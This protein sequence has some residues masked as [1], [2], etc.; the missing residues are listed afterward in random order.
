MLPG[1]FTGEDH[2]YQTLKAN[3]DSMKLI[4]VG[5][6]LTNAQGEL[7][8]IDGAY[9]AWQFNIRDFDIATD[10]YAESSIQLLKSSGID[11]ERNRREGIDS[12]RFG[13]LLIKY[14]L[15]RNRKINYICYQ[16]DYD[17]AYLLKLLTGECMPNTQLEFAQKI[18]TYFGA[19]CDIRVVQITQFRLRGGLQ[20]FSDM[21]GVK[22]VSGTAHQ[23]GSDSLLTSSA[24]QVLKNTYLHV[25]TCKGKPNVKPGLARA[26]VF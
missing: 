10:L 21:L 1:A 11:F 23:A 14:N 4:Q 25:G 15:V 2:A 13:S 8:M 18:H 5:F 6:T 16:G 24:Y 12:K 9:C 3:V 20:K 19:I 26:T 22:R 7:P 17:F